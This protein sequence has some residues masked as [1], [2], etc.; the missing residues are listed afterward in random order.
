MQDQIDAALATKAAAKA[1]ENLILDGTRLGDVP[2]IIRD[3][4]CKPKDIWF[5]ATDSGFAVMDWKTRKYIL[6]DATFSEAIRFVLTWQR[7]VDKP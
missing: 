1:I 3:V 4:V 7:E 2:Q 5:I 6:E